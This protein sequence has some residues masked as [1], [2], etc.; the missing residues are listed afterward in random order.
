VE[1]GIGL[2]NV[3]RVPYFPEPAIELLSQYEAVILADV[4]EPVTFFGYP[5]VESYVLRKDQRKIPLCSAQ[6]SVVEALEYLEDY[7]KTT[8]H[9]KNPHINPPEASKPQLPRGILTAEK[10]CQ[11]L[12]ALQPEGAI[13]VDEGITSAIPYYPMSAGSPI[14]GVL[15]IAGGSI[16]YGMP[17]SL[18]AA[19]AFPDRPVINFQADG[20]AMYT[21]Q[22]LWTEAR[23]RL[24]VKTLI[25]SNR[26][27][28]ILRVEFQ[29]AGI[30]DPGPMAMSLADIDRPKLDWVSISKGMGVPAT[31]VN[32]VENLAQEL[33]RVLA[34]PGPSLIE[35][36]IE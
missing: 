35:M 16:G 22:A 36:I 29:R 9:D 6:H 17:C 13:I 3:S 10:A 14:H 7:L 2:P 11:T 34:E 1:R 20:S 12:A 30:A 27:Y 4:K 33:I 25:C 31:S 5:G 32:T 8:L 28:N 26:G 23:E 24:N 21:I 15:T 19:L 18:G